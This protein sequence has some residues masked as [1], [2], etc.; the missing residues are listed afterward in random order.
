[1]PDTRDGASVR[2]TNRPPPSVDALL[3]DPSMRAAVAEHGAT[4][5]ADAVR[6]V[7]D[8]A[9]IAW[10]DGSNIASSDLVARAIVLLRVRREPRARRVFNCTGTTLHTNLGRAPLAESAI[11]AAVRAMR[12]P[13][14]LEY[15]LATGSRGDRDDLVEPLIRE[16]TG[17][18]AATVVNNNAAAVLLVLDTLGG[19]GARG[20]TAVKEAIVSRGELI[21][22]GGSFRIPD[23]M[24]RAGCR[25]VEV[26][27]TNRT[28]RSDYADAIG[29]KTALVMKAC[30]SNYRIDGYV[31]AVSEAE[32]AEVAHAADIPFVV[33]LGAGA[34]ID[35]SAYG[36]P[37]EPTVAET[38]AAGAD[39]VTFSADKL[40]GGPQ[41]GIVAGRRDLI[42]RMKKNALKRCLRCDKAT[43]AALE[44][45]LLL[46]REP[47]HLV[48]RL[49]TLRWLTRPQADIRALA[50]RLQPSFAAT[51]ADRAAVTVE[52]CLSQIG[53]GAQPVDL[54]PSAALVIRP[55]QRIGGQ[56]TGGRVLA[57][58]DEALRAL[59]VAIIGRIHKGALWLDCRTVEDADDLLASWRHLAFPPSV[60]K[61]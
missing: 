31:A 35:L 1:M 47:E 32:I 9:R 25:L 56:K 60:R 58:I 30:A 6:A 61:G 52:D 33:D 24:R 48:D 38:I 11:D 22:I 26:G 10:R 4:S 46:Y 41:A 36:L 59:P 42:A 18:E 3:R 45:T 54:L 13:V 15:D 27:T 5:A 51:L 17:A 19:Q 14:A 53:S 20:R 57:T 49:T 8:A 7:L 2:A 37:H 12:H 16:L 28:H 44:A 50:E 40:L 39:V 23:I 55:S 43:L 29:P 21:E 34:L